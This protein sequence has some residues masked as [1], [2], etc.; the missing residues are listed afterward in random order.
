LPEQTPL[1]PGLYG[2]FD[3]DIQDR[4]MTWRKGLPSGKPG[5]SFPRIIVGIAEIIGRNFCEY[6]ISGL[7]PATKIQF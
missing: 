4:R 7:L 1:E 5:K 6:G 3:R 2:F